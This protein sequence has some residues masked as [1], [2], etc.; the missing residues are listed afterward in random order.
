MKITQYKN[1][2]LLGN[3]LSTARLLRVAGVVGLIVT[4]LMLIPFTPV[5]PRAGLDPSWGAALNV[6]VA[7]GLVFGKDVIFTFG[8]LAS[9]YTHQYAPE[10]DSIMMVASCLYASS[11]AAIFALVAWP[12]RLFIGI[13]IPL[14]IAFPLMS[15]ANFYALPVFFLYATARLCLPETSPM[16]LRPTSAVLGTLGVTAAALGMIPI[17]K[18]SLLGAAIV[19]VGIAL[20]LLARKN[21]PLSLSLLAIALI[22]LCAWWV[23]SGQH[24]VDLPRYFLAQSP[25][26]SGYTEAMSVEHTPT[27]PI[28]YVIAALVICRGVWLTMREEDSLVALAVVAG[29]IWALFVAF[30]A[31]FIRHDM[32]ALISSSTLLFVTCAALC[33]VKRS[34]Q[35]AIIVVIALAAALLGQARSLNAEPMRLHNAIHDTLDGIQARLQ[36]ND[37]MH[38]RYLIALEAVR[39]DLPISGVEGSVDLY[40]VNLTLIF[41]NGLPWAGRPVLQSYSAYTPSLLEADA[42][43]LRGANAPKNVFFTFKPIDNRLP[44][45]D[46]S[47]SLIALLERY[48]VVDYNAS[49]LHMVKTDSA[50]GARLL[51]DETTQQTAQWGQAID[52]KAR[53]PL[54]VSIDVQQTLAGR[55]LE[56]LFK[57]P[58][59]EIDVT[60]DDGSVMHRRYIP[61]IGQAGF[62]VSPYLENEKDFANLAERKPPRLPVKSFTLVSPYGG[63][64]KG[65]FLVKTTPIQVGQS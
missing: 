31:G 18:A 10:T 49:Y 47:M 50:T 27:G 60:L 39:R 33:F 48:R 54:W 12:N 41:A 62:I 5:M 7:H 58:P 22:S 13:A 44:A 40:P 30:K 56:D 6:A 17:I 32:H 51:Q 15:D 37:V 64:W 14:I 59:L 2:P 4:T 3:T 61:K 11:F 53:G 23:I 19:V 21:L 29:T 25:I 46:D 42:N 35:V 63:L 52:V 55:I 24:L 65:S 43:H 9:V 16:Y 8:P 45:L 28:L 1:L 20:I 34:Q 26:V 57:L 38:S 36:S